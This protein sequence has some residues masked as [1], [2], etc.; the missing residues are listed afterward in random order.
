[1]LK[2]D[3]N[4]AD[5][6]WDFLKIAKIDKKIDA[7]VYKLYG[8]TEEELDF[9]VETPEFRLAENKLVDLFKS[10]L[11]SELR[12]LV[13]IR[14]DKDVDHNAITLIAD[15]AMLVDIVAHAVELQISAVQARF[16][17]LSRKLFVL[18]EAN[19]VGRRENTI[20]TDLFGIGDR[21]EKVRR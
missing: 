20:E 14:K 18:R 7:E 9:I 16:I 2:S 1:M 6:G 13:E 19:A 15:A 21:F 10:R 5:G 17:S 11:S 3:F 12:N 4:S 8:F